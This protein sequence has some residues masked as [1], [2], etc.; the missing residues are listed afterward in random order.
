MN[1]LRPMGC[2]KELIDADPQDSEV[3]N[4]AAN[5][6]YWHMSQFARDYHNMYGELPS[7]ALL[8]Q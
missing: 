6:G 1:N 7:K 3:S 5:W 8:R 2:Q 4:V